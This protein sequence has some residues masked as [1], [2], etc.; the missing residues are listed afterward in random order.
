MGYLGSHL[1]EDYYSYQLL[2]CVAEQ[3]DANDTGDWNKLQDS[4]NAV[5]EKFTSANKRI[6]Q[7]A[8][9]PHAKRTS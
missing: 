5:V 7:G 6:K 3:I 4:L 8:K 1:S 9:R 2:E